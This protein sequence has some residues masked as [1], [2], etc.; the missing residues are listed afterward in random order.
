MQF[1]AYTFNSQFSELVL[2]QSSEHGL[3]EPLKSKQ[4]GLS[5]AVRDSMFQFR[6]QAF[7]NI[8]LAHEL[9]H[10]LISIQEGSGTRDP[11]KDRDQW[12]FQESNR[13]TEK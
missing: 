10:L 5:K 4:L 9:S 7:S 8:R 1:V 13:H 2:W 3:Q 12:N 6:K 11:H